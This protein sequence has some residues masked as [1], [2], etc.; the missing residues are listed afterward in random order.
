MTA[1]IAERTLF[2]PYCV[3]CAGKSVIT[4]G[5]TSRLE[6]EAWVAKHDA[7]YH[8]EPEGEDG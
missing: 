4:F 6:A 1:Q 7:E 2:E 3:P 8:P 5:T